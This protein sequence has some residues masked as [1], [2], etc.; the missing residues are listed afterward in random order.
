LNPKAGIGADEKVL[1]RAIGK[2]CHTAAIRS[3]PA[4]LLEPS[5]RDD[6][7]LFHASGEFRNPILR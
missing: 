7:T 1:H 2:S 5:R 3:N 4:L 6:D